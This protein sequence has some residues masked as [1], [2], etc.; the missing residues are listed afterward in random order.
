MS[1]A[2]L[3]KSY[4]SKS[5]GIQGQWNELDDAPSYIQ[6]I[7]TGQILDG[8]T[9][10]KLSALISGVPT[11]WARARLFKFAL[12][13]LAMPDPAIKD[14]G[15]LKFYELLYG[16]WKGL[17]AIIALF[18]DRIKFS[19]PVYMNVRGDDYDIASAFGRMLFDDKDLWSNQ[20]ELA[21][22]P[23]AQPFIHLIYYRDHLVGGT[24]PMTGI[25]TGVNY[26]QIES[27]ASDVIWYRDGKFEDPTRFLT[28]DQL[29]KV[30]LFVKNMNNNLV[31]FESKVNSQRNGK[32][33]LD[34][35]GLKQMSWK[36]EQELKEV[37]SSSLDEIGIIAKYTNLSVPFKD[38][39]HNEVPV[40]LKPD[41]TFTYT[42]PNGEYQ[43][44]SDIQSL[45]AD[46]ESLLGWSEKNDAYP[47]LKD[48]PVY[49]LKVNDVTKNGVC[50]F[51]IPFSEQGVEIFRNN[52][53]SILGYKPEQG[54]SL[55][56]EI[57]NNKDNALLSVQFV[58]QIDEKRVSLGVREYSI[59]WQTKPQKVIL[60]PNF[61]SDKWS[62]YYLY[63]QQSEASQPRFRPIFQ[64]R[65]DIIKAGNAFFTP[66]YKSP[67]GTDLPV[68]IQELVATPQN[69][70]DTL[71][72]YQIAYY[73]KPIIGLSVAVKQGGNEVNAGFLMIRQDIVKDITDIAIADTANIGF[74]FGSNN[75]CVYYKTN[76]SNN[77][78]PVEFKNFRSLLVGQEIPNPN[79]VADMDE[80]FFFTNFDA[81]NGQFKSWLHEHDNRC[82]PNTQSEEIAGGVPVNRPNVQVNKMGECIE[83]Q[84]GRLHYNMKW[85]A[86]EDGLKQK[87]AFIKSLWLQTCAFLYSQHIMPARINWSCPGAMQPSDV[88]ELG[89]IFD[90]LETITPIINHQSMAAPAPTTEAE[91]VCSYAIAQPD[92][93]LTT[94]NMF[95]GIDVGGSTSDIMLLAN[96]LKTGET[97]LI[98]ESSVRIA[99][100]AFFRAVSDSRQFREALVTF[101]EGHKTKVNVMNIKE[102]NE[103][104][105]KAK[106]PY[107]LNCIFDQLRPEEY[108]VFY[109]SIKDNAC[110]VFAIPAYVTGI[111]LFYSGMLIGKAIKD[112]QLSSSLQT[113][114]ILPFG[115]GGRLFH[116]LYSAA[117]VNTDDYYKTCLNKGIGCILSKEVGINVRQQ[118]AANNKTEVARGLCNPQPFI[119][120]AEAGKT[121]ICGEI[122]IQF[123]DAD[124]ILRTID[125]CEE[126]DG[127]YF[128]D[129]TK[130]SFSRGGNFDSFM[131]VFIHF[132]S[133]TTKIYQ[134]EGEENELKK[135]IRDVPGRIKN[136]LQNDEEYAK[137]RRSSET[138]FPFHQPIIIAE[139]A[140]YLSTLIEK[141]FAH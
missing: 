34:L 120:D 138:K 133:K 24:S 7:K 5:T 78:S 103:P 97:S 18:P 52:L 17:I 131:D 19:A 20:D 101:H 137:A 129:L 16:E 49:F 29:Q 10:D 74:D 9:A 37:G 92:F 22:N 116:W 77:V 125:V 36:W 51:T 95:L 93:G 43:R 110:F 90:S 108:K 105:N 100:G 106:A 33:R 84:V 134:K 72:R 11:P 2:L 128:K 67:D 124:G 58:V 104:V 126:L 123:R 86:S 115:K 53:P 69:S 38:L 64:S 136:F 57:I 55:K 98:K 21:K 54:I 83:T 30:Y 31:D 111:L 132:I 140:S 75:T 14:S 56:A 109:E 45:L 47:S 15:L 28:Q 3:I 122:G 96:D 139:A 26:S 81:K 35:S 65:R 70:G 63:S 39:F 32:A 62:R 60:W 41:Y 59:R 82:V 44:I 4:T 85:K 112:G 113:V 107:Y 71:P 40:Y 94:D 6:G 25:F 66:D 127:S 1:R 80:L 68:N 119:R 141:I 61:I 91:A 135:D 117:G 23:G 42:D 99:A 114:E 27:D 88:T 8:M 102:L 48:A 12:Q 118:L 76:N 89:L 87:K 79:R 50:Y 121:D 130:F 13:T 46:E 73:D